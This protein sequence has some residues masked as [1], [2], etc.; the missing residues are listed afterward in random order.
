MPPEVSGSPANRPV[1]F[2]TGAAGGIG[3]AVVSRLRQ[4]G[5]RVYATDV[6][7]AAIPCTE[8]DFAAASLDVTDEAAVRA[9][10]A[11]CIQQFGRLDHV[12]HLAGKGGV[13]PLTEVQLA[14]WRELL[15]INL[16]SAFLM[17]KYT[18]AALTASRGTLTLMAST[19][20]LNGGSALSGP[21]YAVAKAG[22]INLTRYL[23][24]EWAPHRIRVNCLAPGPI[25]TPMVG[26]F[27]AATRAKLIESV[28]L[29]RLGLAQEVAAAVDFLTSDGAGYMTGTVMNISGGVVLD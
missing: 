26:R 22:I 11:A 27:D 8:S 6:A 1:A 13:G 25:D 17:A 21:A 29:K 4:R 14:E 15:A 24:K 28:P 10:V 12:V 2:V 19:N 20:A 9:A 16:D 3:K 23:A 18:A 5:V 7:L